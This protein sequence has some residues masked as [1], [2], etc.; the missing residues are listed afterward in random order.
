MKIFLCGRIF[1]NVDDFFLHKVKKYP[2]YNLFILWEDK[3]G[4][5]KKDTRRN[6]SI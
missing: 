1:Y 6:F 5:L 4:V 3:K 2:H